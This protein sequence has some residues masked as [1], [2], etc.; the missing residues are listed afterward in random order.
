MLQ[1]SSIFK[2]LYPRLNFVVVGRCLIIP[3]Q[4]RRLKLCVANKY[5]LATPSPYM[6][7]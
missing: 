3:W 6:K 4:L 1:Q 7:D 2:L 5:A